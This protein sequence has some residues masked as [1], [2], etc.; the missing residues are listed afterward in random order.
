MSKKAIARA[1]DISM[2]TVEQH[3]SHLMEK[4]GIPDRV[5]LTRFAIRERLVEA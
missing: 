3:C 1:R 4:L 5:D 2:K